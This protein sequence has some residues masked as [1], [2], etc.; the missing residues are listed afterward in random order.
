MQEYAKT[1]DYKKIIGRQPVDVRF[2]FQQNSKY[3]SDCIRFLLLSINRVRGYLLKNSFYFIISV[4][5]TL[6]SHNSHLIKPQPAHDS[7]TFSPLLEY[8]HASLPRRI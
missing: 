6:H 5:E 4:L 3:L 1:K 2:C 7:L 8:N